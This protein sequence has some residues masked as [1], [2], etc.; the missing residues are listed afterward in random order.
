VVVSNRLGM[1]NGK[2]WS[3]QTNQA[4]AHSLASVNTF[5]GRLD[6]SSMERGAMDPKLLD[7]M[8]KDEEGIRIWNRCQPYLHIRHHSPRVSRLLG[9]RVFQ[10]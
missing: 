9:L 3:M 2:R 8:G 6:I 5:D 1:E 7:I 4:L 10:H